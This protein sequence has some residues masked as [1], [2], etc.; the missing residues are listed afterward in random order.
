MQAEG[1]LAALNDQ[2]EATGQLPV[3]LSAR[4]VWG[5]N[6]EE[7]LTPTAMLNECHLLGLLLCRQRPPGPPPPAQQGGGVVLLDKA[8]PGMTL[9]E[10]RDSVDNALI[11]LPA[12]RLGARPATAFIDGCFHRFGALAAQ[13]GDADALN[14]SLAVEEHDDPAAPLRLSRPCIRR[15]LASFLV[16]YRHMHLAAIAQPVPP[17]PY[18]CGIRKHHMEASSDAFA[19]L[20]MRMRLPAAAVLNYKQDFTGFFNHISQVV[21]FH[22]PAYEPL[23]RVPLA[24]AA[25][26][27]PLQVLPAIQLLY[28][29][30]RTYYEEDAFDITRPLGHW[31][32]IV[33][34]GRVYLAGPDARVYHSD[35]VTALVGVYQARPPA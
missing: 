20:A 34:P 21:Y 10:L 13:G 25:R 12:R 16:M 32:W 30:I 5:C 4:W 28:P 18:D 8:P 17:A 7:P 6:P 19:L 3:N 26:G 1:P 15:F 35:N 9:R 24:E 14:D 29:D 2:L 11:E 22:N 33:L 31:A 23:R 27:D